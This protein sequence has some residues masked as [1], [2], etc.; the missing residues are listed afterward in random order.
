[1][2]DS[3]AAQLGVTREDIVA[4]DVIPEPTPE[5]RNG[6]TILMTRG[7]GAPIDVRITLADGSVSIVSMGCGGIPSS[8]A[9]FDNP[10]LDASSIIGGGYHDIPCPGEPP[11]GCATPVPSVAPEAAAEAT[12]LHVDRLDIPID[13]VGDYA[14]RLG[15]ARLPTGL[16][17]AAEFAL[18]DDWPPR[19]TI[20]GGGVW[21]EVRSLEPDGRP[22]RNIYEHGWREGTEHVAAFVVFHV[23]RFDPG[24]VLS[25]SD[26]VVR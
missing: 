10:H 1:M 21:L 20:L 12:E 7:G 4:I 9:C 16:L 8:P 14:V 23:D 19:V 13:H 24:A 2:T 25:I 3:A 6:V 26:V 22:F 18:V 11:D 17:T 5:T 15:E